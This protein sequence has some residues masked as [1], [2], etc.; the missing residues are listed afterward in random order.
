MQYLESLCPMVL[1]GVSRNKFLGITIFGPNGVC[2]YIEW[3][4]QIIGIKYLLFAAL[5]IPSGIYRYGLT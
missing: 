5:D 1:Q 2:N 4:F 3:M